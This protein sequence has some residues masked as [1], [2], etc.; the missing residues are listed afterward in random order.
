V[1]F[2]GHGL[3]DRWIALPGWGAVGEIALVDLSRAHLLDNK[4]VYA[5]CCNSLAQLGAVFPSQC[6][7]EFVGYSAPFWFETNNHE[8]FRDI[9]NSS[10]GAFVRGRSASQVASDLST[11]WGNLRHEFAN[12]RLCNRPQAIMAAHF[13]DLN[14]QGVGARP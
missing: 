5:G 8:E 12:G 11:E 6:S 4:R 13:A 14:R 7:G 3:A 1:V 2:F 9:V 10:V